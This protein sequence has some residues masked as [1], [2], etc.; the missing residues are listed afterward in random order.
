[1]TNEDQIR[2]Q[3]LV[4]D[5]LAQRY[6]LLATMYYAYE[7]KKR[8]VKGAQA[9]FH[10]ALNQIRSTQL[11]EELLH[12]QRSQESQWPV[13]SQA[14]SVSGNTETAQSPQHTSDS[15]GEREGVQSLPLI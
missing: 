9:A 11:F 7:C 8:G 10:R 13:G 1:M 12:A 14:G 2:A 15:S 4:I 3:Q 6:S 5:K